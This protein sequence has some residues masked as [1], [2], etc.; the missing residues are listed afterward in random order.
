MQRTNGVRKASPVRGGGA[1]R[2]RGFTAVFCTALSI[3]HRVIASQCSHWRGNPFPLAKGCD[4]P[5]HSRSCWEPE[6]PLC[7]GR[8]RGAPEGLLQCCWLCCAT[9]DYSR[10]NL[11]LPK[12]ERPPGAISF[13]SR[14]KIWKKGVPKDPLSF[15]ISANSAADA[16]ALT[17]W[18]PALSHWC[19]ARI[20][21]S[22]GVPERCPI[23]L[24]KRGS[25]HPLGNS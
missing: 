21:T 14:R 23:C 2:R 16:F 10:T 25:G 15:G 8:W 7:K 4:F 22:G 9:P 12:G 20:L 5:L 13:V 6:P 19:L 24:Q 17:Y 3:F 1:K 11:A 18:F